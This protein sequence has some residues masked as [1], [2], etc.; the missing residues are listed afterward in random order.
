VRAASF[1]R[2]TPPAAK[3]P[4]GGIAMIYDAYSANP[5][6]RKMF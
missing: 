6:G 3:T 5:V 1:N 2:Q 4:P